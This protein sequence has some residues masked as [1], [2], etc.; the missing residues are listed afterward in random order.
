MDPRGFPL[1]PNLKQPTPKYLDLTK[2]GEN[3]FDELKKRPN[4]TGND[5]SEAQKSGKNPKM[6]TLPGGLQYQ[7]IEEGFGLTPKP[8]GVT[9]IHYTSWLADG[10]ECD[11]SLKSVKGPFKFK[12]GEGAVLIGIEQGLKG[13]KVGGTRVLVIPPNM[14]YGANGFPEKKIPPNATLTYKIKLLSTGKGFE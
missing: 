6:V 1:V 10:T 12:Y 11:S 3:Y 14:A 9:L 7:D 2:A 13:M 8:G 5:F 4:T